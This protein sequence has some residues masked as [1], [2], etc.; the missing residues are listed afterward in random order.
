MCFNESVLGHK[1]FI[2]QNAVIHGDNETHRLECVLLHV[3]KSEP[4]EEERNNK[5][6]VTIL[7][8]ITLSTGKCGSMQTI[9][10]LS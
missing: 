6:F 1:K 10:L 8:W 3:E 2:L 7:N 4:K 5:P 9:C